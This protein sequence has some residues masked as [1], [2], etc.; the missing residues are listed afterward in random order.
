M[1]A[2]CVR[3]FFF[4]KQLW[5]GS[6]STEGPRDL[7]AWIASIRS[8][9]CGSINRE[10]SCSIR[11]GISIQRLL[12]FSLFLWWSWG[13][14]AS[15]IKLVWPCTSTLRTTLSWP[16]GRS[17][18]GPAGCKRIPAARPSSPS[19]ASPPPPSSASPPRPAPHLLLR[20]GYQTALW[21]KAALSSQRKCSNPRTFWQQRTPLKNVLPSPA[22]LNLADLMSPKGQPLH[23]LLN[24]N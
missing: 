7:N 19:P 11:A 21:P 4:F 15:K 12:W 1:A 16:R 3:F 13:Q 6:I 18:L 9:R 17:V 5:A 24:S 10:S 22:T 14:L 23:S 2:L 20:P 8:K